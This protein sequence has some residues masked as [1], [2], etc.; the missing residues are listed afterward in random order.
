MS[1]SFTKSCLA[2]ALCSLYT[3][4]ASAQSQPLELDNMVVTA[5][6]FSQQIKDAPASI[7]V[8]SREQIENK[9]YRDVTDA[10]RDVPGV[11]VTGGG[12]SS[13]IS[14][15]GMASKYTL[16]LVDGKRQDSR[17]TRPN[18][19]GAG[20][21]QGWMP[22]LEAIERIEVVR[23]PMSSLY[24]SD[25]MG[26]VINI[27]TR[28]VTP[29]WYGGVRTE[30]TFQD[31]SDSG[32]Y[33]S[34]SAFISGPLVENLVGLQLY[35][36]R[37]RRDE[38]HIV[39][40][41]NEQSTDSATAK[42]SF[43]PDTNNDIT[44]EAGKSEQERNATLGRSARSSSSQN[45]YDR[46]HFSV[47]HSG[48]WESVTTDSYLQREK[49]ENPG[50]KMELENTV[51]NSQASFYSDSHT[52]TFGGQYKYED[53]SDQGNQLASA[54]T[55][56]QLTRWS[57]AL[58]AEDEWRLTDQFALTGGLRMD[59]DENYGTHWSPRLYGVYHPTEQWTIKGG[60]ST[61]YRS[62]DI[63]AAVDD[64]GQITGG[65]GDPAIIVGNSALK[66]EESVSQE[67]G[68]IWDNLEG[69]STG[70]TVFNTDFKDKI[71]EQRRCTD[72]TGNASGQ[73]QIAGT[74]YKFISDRVNVDEA[75]MRGVEAT[76]DWAITQRLTLA[77][78][79]TFTD[80][81]Q[82]SGALKGKALNQMPRHMFN[83]TLDWQNTDQLGTWTRLNYR[84]KTSDYLGRTT[85]SDGTPSYTF[86]DVGGTYKV[87]K[88]LKLLAGVYNVFNKEVDYA[89][90]QTVLDGRRY[91]VGMDLS[92]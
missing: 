73:C 18:S 81:E 85:M 80:S 19:D 33:S 15:R 3:A 14:I 54:A 68:F 2:L 44:V 76:L 12:S 48:R 37:S 32:D 86:V 65:G 63:R 45:D 71:T 20:I 28:K 52:T 26:G 46:T 83:A 61:G 36:Q 22:P 10:L 43:T 67:I 9:S 72:S 50:R 31:R 62:P 6:G 11:V 4:Q 27:I 75:Q 40:G 55:L 29:Q 53:L 92:F 23:G 24:G 25:A 78:N 91:T 87:T 34:T 39:N 89:E 84:G 42:L 47:S 70:L 60:V 8:I 82:K 16:M 21:E 90:Y 57:W 69:F 5:S 38:D 41:F 66:P 51:L 58:F 49:I 64:W 1:P 7:S 59:R 56:N 17:A 74:S 79:Y 77:T 88:N 35:G 13:D 30:T